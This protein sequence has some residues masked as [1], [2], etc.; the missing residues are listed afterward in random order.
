MVTSALLSL[1]S[2]ALGEASE[3]TCRTSESTILEA[4]PTVPVRP[5]DETAAAVRP[6]AQHL[7]KMPQSP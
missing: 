5:S 2:L 4:R 7:A 1:G 3:L 6:E